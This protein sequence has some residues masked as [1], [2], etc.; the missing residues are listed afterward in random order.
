[1]LQITSV[2][3]DHT[4]REMLALGRIHL[5]LKLVK[6]AE[7]EQLP[8][9]AL[10]DNIGPDRL[11]KAEEQKTL[12]LAIIVAEVVQPINVLLD[13]YLLAGLVLG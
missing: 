10:Q 12:K 13:K 7:T 9:S 6:R 2:V 11:A 3:L 8:T 4:R 5:T 1:V